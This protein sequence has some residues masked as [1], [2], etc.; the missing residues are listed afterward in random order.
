MN[1]TAGAR[2]LLLHEKHLMTEE[3]PFNLLRGE[4]N[5]FTLLLFQLTHS[6][7]KYIHMHKQHLLYRRALIVVETAKGTA[8]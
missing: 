7:L 4:L 8:A 3:I 1:A 6:G 2:E 5:F